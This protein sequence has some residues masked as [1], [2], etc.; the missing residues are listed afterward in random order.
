QS[1]R[2]AAPPQACPLLNGPEQKEGRM[3][4]IPPKEAVAEPPLESV[5]LPTTDSAS[6]I[7]AALGLKKAVLR[8]ATWSLIGYGL[9]QLLKLASLIIVSNLLG[10]TAKGLFEVVFAVLLGLQL[11]S[12]LGI[13]LSLVRSERG[14]EP[15]FM[16]T[17]WTLQIVRGLL[18]WLAT[19]VM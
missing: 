8:S 13:G 9:S 12:D 15:A 16:N 6:P 3:H 19:I 18:L 14:D 4:W 7:P 11:F 2:N 10:P 17:A 1:V 5:A